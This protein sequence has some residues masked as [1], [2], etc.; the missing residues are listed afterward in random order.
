MNENNNLPVQHTPVQ[1]QGMLTPFA[2]VNSFE[3]A[4]RMA[5]ALATSDL[6]PKQFSGNLGNTLLALEMSN[7]LNMPV[8][9]VLQNLHVIHG[10]PSF[11]ASF[12]IALVN[13]SKRFDTPLLFEYNKEKTSC[14]AYAMQGDHKITGAT[15]NMEMASR[16]GWLNKNGSKWQTMPE[17]MLQYRAG[18]FFARAYVPDLLMGMQ[19]QEEVLDV[20]AEVVENSQDDLNDMVLPVIEN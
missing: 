10:K 17:L 1:A 13:A 11:S 2:D 12:M 18:A 5:K 19:S 3:N 20:E 16:E 8:F 15:V 9:S 6:V 14:F 4:Q 7:R